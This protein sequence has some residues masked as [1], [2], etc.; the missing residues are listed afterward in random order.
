MT[1]VLISP[2]ISLTIKKAYFESI[3][4]YYSKEEAFFYAFFKAKSSIADRIL[5]D[6]NI[7]IFM[8]LDFDAFT[9][10]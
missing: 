7:F 6:D 2:T 10:P 8:S 3:C 4:L 5:V 9:M 1:G